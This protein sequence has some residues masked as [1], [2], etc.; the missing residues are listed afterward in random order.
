MSQST[1]A[2]Q[3]L[4]KLKD[5]QIDL[6]IDKDVKP[7]AQQQRR[8]PFHLREKV[9]KE[10]QQ[11]HAHDIIEKV[12]E[13]KETEWISPLVIVPK[14]NDKIRLCVDM[15]AANEAI[16]RVRH[17]IPT[18][19]DVCHE[20]NGAKFFTKLDLSQAYH[21]IELSPQSRYI[22]TFA[23]HQGLYRYKRLNYGNFSTYLTASF[24]RN[25]GRQKY[26]GRYFSFRPHQ[27]AYKIGR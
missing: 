14:Q 3:G 11:L 1:V 26:R 21:Q 17:P 27:G 22:T 16:K 20:L 8:V 2:F 7:V 6:I 25:E 9:E 15:R 19:K 10:L 4:G 23:T 12:P 24:P 18:V 13:N 5:K